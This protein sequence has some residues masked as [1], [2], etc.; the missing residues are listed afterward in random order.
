[1]S[2]EQ[3]I[4]NNDERGKELVKILL[5]QI[6]AT[7]IEVT[8]DQFD[9]VDMFFKSKRGQRVAVEVKN[10]APKD[11][12]YSTYLLE[13]GKYLGIKQRMHDKGATVGLYAYIFGDHLY[14][15][16]IED[17]V[18]NTALQRDCKVKANGYSNRWTT[19]DMYYFDKEL[20]LAKFEL[21]DG[22]WHKL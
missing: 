3:L 20:Y 5:Q 6:G 12:H 21:V 19:K 14:L 15:Y 22:K 2:T 11:E 10:R 17:I 16:N 7:E 18:A 4:K 1:M 9:S 13:L 8:Q